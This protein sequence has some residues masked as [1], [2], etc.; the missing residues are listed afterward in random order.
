MN[1]AEK[2][3]KP[4]PRTMV[5]DAKGQVGKTVQLDA[6]AAVI[7]HQ[8][9]IVFLVLR[10]ISGTMQAVAF[11]KALVEKLN[12]LTPESVVSVTGLVKEAKQA[13]DGVEI[14]VQSYEVLSASHPELAIPVHEKAGETSQEKR[15]DWR[16]LDLRK[17]HNQLVFKAAT[18]LEESLRE[19]W[20]TNGYLEIHSPK[21]ISTA[22]E[23]GSEVFK[24][25]YFDG[26]AFLAQSPQFYKQMAMAAGFERVFEVGPVFRAEPSFTSRHATEFTG[27]DAELSFIESH[28]DV[29]AENERMVVAMLEGV[30][31]KYDKEIEREFGRKLAVPKLPFPK[32]TMAEAKQKL[33]AAKVKSDHPGDLT[34]EEERKLS[35]IIKQE[36]GHEFVFVIDYPVE[37]RAFYHMRHDDDP[38]LTKGYDLLWNGVEIVTGAQREH[39]VDVLEKQA[40]ESGVDLKHLDFYLNFFRYGCPPHGGMGMGAGRILMKLFDVANIR[41]V[42][43][44]HRSVSR[45]TP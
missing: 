31:K 14:E 1:S 32:V 9:K 24:I 23:S 29:M 15:L 10:D 35:E 25:E 17:P 30:V 13:P 22:S 45:I 2:T 39:R 34:P 3:Q 41:E 43:F 4:L 6:W 11:D 19:Y 36:T 38:K 37:R 40:K 42:T 26:E 18:E 44:L 33:A 5:A 21:I 8:G 7:R 20:T 28:H 16:W 27:F 12:E